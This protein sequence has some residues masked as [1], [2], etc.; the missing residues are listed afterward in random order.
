MSRCNATPC[1]KPE[2]LIRTPKSIGLLHSKSSRLLYSLS[3]ASSSMWASTLNIDILVVRIGG[4]LVHRLLVV[5]GA[6]PR[7]LL[8][9]ALHVTCHRPLIFV[10]FPD[11]D[12]QMVE[13]KVWEL[14]PARRRTHR[15]I[16]PELSSLCFGGNHS[17][18]LN[19]PDRF[20]Y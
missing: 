14:P 1:T 15:G 20:V 4:F 2:E 10:N 17:L 8:R 12:E 16:C 18:F 5:L 6:L 13:Q 3:L 7:C 11:M 19:V 9:Q